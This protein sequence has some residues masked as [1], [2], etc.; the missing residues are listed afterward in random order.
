MSWNVQGN[1]TLAGDVPMSSGLATQIAAIAPDFVALQECAFC[2]R[3]LD[4]LPERYRLIAPT[5]AGVAI[6]YDGR[7]WAVAASGELV[8]GDDDDG[9]GPRRA[10]WARFR[11]VDGESVID[12][13]STHFCVSVRSRDDRCSAER[14]RAYAEAIVADLHERASAAAIIA[15]DLNV[16]EGFEAAPAVRFF[17]GNAMRPLVD[18]FRAAHPKEGGATFAGNDFAPPGRIDYLLATRPVRVLLASTP[19]APGLSDH[20]PVVARLAFSGL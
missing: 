1:V 18:V 13:Y 4:Q 16:F 20:R 9:W 11:R 2:D 17:T 12:V 15:G 19:E 14:Q 5:E 10:R 8:L 6:A 7:A 3:L